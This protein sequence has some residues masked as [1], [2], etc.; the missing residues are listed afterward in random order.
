MIICLL[1]VKNRIKYRN[2]CTVMVQK[3]LRGYLA[4]KQHQPRYKG[5][6][7]INAIRRNMK[8]M[9]EIANQVKKERESMLNQIKEID[10]QI[11][12]A[13]TKIKVSFGQNASSWN[14]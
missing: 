8:Q 6:A 4:R 10:G 14:C 5:I 7:K 11:D 3:T 1:S 9:E 12:L 2:K 13:I